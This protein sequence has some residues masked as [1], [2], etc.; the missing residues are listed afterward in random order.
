VG[1]TPEILRPLDPAL[2]F[3]AA[4]PEAIADGLRRFL[5][6]DGRAAGA[7]PEACRA[8]ATAHYAWGGVVARLETAFRQLVQLYAERPRR[9]ETG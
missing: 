1:A 4:T 3:G 8:Y 7:R 6:G 5:D 9:D 2:L